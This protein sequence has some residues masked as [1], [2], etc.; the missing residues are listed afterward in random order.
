MIRTLSIGTHR[1]PATPIFAALTALVVLGG[2][3]ALERSSGAAM[4]VTAVTLDLVI[5]IPGLHYL[6]L[7]RGRGLPA[8]SLIPVFRL[9]LAA[10]GY[11]L[12]TDQRE[13]Y[14]LLAPLARPAEL[15]MAGYVLYRFHLGWRSL[16]A[17]D[18]ADVLD[19]HR[20]G[21]RAMLPPTVP[22]I[23][24]A[25]AAIAFEA[26][27]VWFATRSWRS[28]PQLPAGA[29]AFTGH[30][31]SGYAGVMVALLLVLTVEV[32]AVH[33]LV[34]LWSPTA[35]WI[36][37]GLGI[38]GA[39]WLVG[40]LQAVRLRPSWVDDEWLCTRVGLR[41]AL[42]VP[43][44]DVKRV[45]LLASGETVEDALRLSLPNARRVLIE[46]HVPATAVG[47]YGFQKTAAAI[48]LGVDDPEEFLLALET[49]R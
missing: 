43:L 16:R 11:I 8:I 20:I 42:T 30:Q 48:E 2:M 35:A 19:R 24:R 28:R 38:Y 46:L 23:D 13:L 40:D 6:L 33:L 39:V 47:M 18:T 21:V 29:T 45:R 12:P 14:D 17:A 3:V 15:V 44:S 5:V 34:S 22:S 32:V 37:T 1:L 7:V 25:A 10:A 9:S 4:V 31:R 27:L 49:A 41:W 36:L 26:A